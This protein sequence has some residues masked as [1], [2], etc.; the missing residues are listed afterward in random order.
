MKL[1]IT[2]SLVAIALLMAVL[3][4]TSL[5]TTKTGN[6]KSA[7]VP[8]ATPGPTRAVPDQYPEIPEALK[9][10]QHAKDHLEKAK[11]DFGGHRA[12]G[13]HACDEAIRQLEICMKYDK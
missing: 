5:A 3:F 8:A 2:G 6:A 4:G 1:R 11:H 13:I 10:L 12:D 7:S 9:A